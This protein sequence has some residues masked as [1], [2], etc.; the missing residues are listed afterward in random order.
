MKRIDLLK[1]LRA[2]GCR[3]LREGGSH[4]I[5]IN[6]ANGRRAP[7]MRHPTFSRYTGADACKKLGVPTPPSRQ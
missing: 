1:H 4:S 5:W 6:P 3:L 2:C 7:V